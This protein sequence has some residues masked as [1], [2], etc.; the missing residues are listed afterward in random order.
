MLSNE[1]VARAADIFAL[2]RRENAMV[3]GLPPDCAPRSIE[4]AYRIQD[5][6]HARLGGGID[7]WFGACTNEDIQTMLGLREPYYGRLRSSEVFASPAELDTSRYPPM[8][9]ECEFGFRVGRGFGP[10]DHPVSPEA[11]AAAVTEVCPMIEVVAGHL[12]D[13]PN[14]D[15]F[16]VI[17]DNGTDGAW[18]VGDGIPD[19]RAV[20]LAGS[21]VTLRS[22][23]EVVREGFGSRVLGNP[24]DAFEWLVNA[25]IRD[26]KAIE[27]GHVHNTGTATEIYWASAGERIEAEFE[28]IGTVALTLV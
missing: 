21:R 18:V 23:G 26:G 1:A 4:D 5:A 28:G 10:A 6:L 12:E 25:V 16:T 19:W 15:V 14:Q 11:V 22:N 13:W 17:A 27:A 7:G 24:L 8:V 20:D 3:P 9:I 2:A